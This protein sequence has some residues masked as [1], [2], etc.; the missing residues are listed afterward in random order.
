MVGADEGSSGLACEPV[1]RVVARDSGAGPGRAAQA[2][3]VSVRRALVGVPCLPLFCARALLLL[4]D[5]RLPGWCLS[6]SCA[7][8]LSLSEASL[9]PS[10]CQK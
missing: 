10:L 4:L 9:K 6:G 7:F 8:T 1:E 3:G 5:L 2:W